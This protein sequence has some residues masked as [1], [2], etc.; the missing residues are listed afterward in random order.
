MFTYS[1]KNSI[2]TG[3][4]LFPGFPGFYWK[5]FPF[6]G[7]FYKPRNMKTLVE[8]AVLAST[9]A[10]SLQ[11]RKEGS[12]RGKALNQGNLLF[13]SAGGYTTDV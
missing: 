3:I 10:S 13:L 2:F 9:L 6:P 4:L 1:H 5:N 12:H 7:F 8:T 11:E